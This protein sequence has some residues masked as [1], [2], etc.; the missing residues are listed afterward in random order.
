MIIPLIETPH[1]DLAS[2]IRKH[3]SGTHHCLGKVIKK[4]GFQA[5]IRLGFVLGGHFLGIQHMEYFLPVFSLLD[6]LDSKR[7]AL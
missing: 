7:Q 4:I 2:G 3:F 1:S 6:V 5:L